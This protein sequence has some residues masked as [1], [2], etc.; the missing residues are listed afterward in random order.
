M[1]EKKELAQKIMLTFEKM[2]TDVSQFQ[3]ESGLTCLEGCGKCCLNPET[4]ATPLE[5]LPLALHLIEE[6]TAEVMWEK[7]SQTSQKSC[8]LYIAN[9]ENPHQGRCGVYAFRPSLC[10]LFGASGIQDKYGE[11]RLSVCHLIQEDKK[12]IY[13]KDRD[14]KSIPSM[15]EAMQKLYEV[16]PNLAQGTKRM[17]EALKEMLEVLLLEQSLEGVN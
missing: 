11:M 4:Y 10:R 8:L 5:F 17:N 1:K 9:P 2:S 14:L 15:T 13:Q 3:K 7:L 6:G 16:H 12:E